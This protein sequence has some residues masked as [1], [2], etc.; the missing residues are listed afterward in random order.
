MSSCSDYTL[1]KAVCLRPPEDVGTSPAP[2]ANHVFYLGVSAQRGCLFLI[3]LGAVWTNA[4]GSYVAFTKKSVLNK[5]VSSSVC[6][7]I[8]LV[9][10]CDLVQLSFSLMKSEYCREQTMTWDLSHLS[11][12]L[13]SL[14]H[15]PDC[16]SHSSAPFPHLQPRR[17]A[18]HFLIDHKDVLCSHLLSGEGKEPQEECVNRTQEMR[19]PVC[20]RRERE[21]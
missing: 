21:K 14:P 3:F 9:F 18:G 12:L 20:E 1:H 6:L 2:L 5:C 10:F 7:M 17:R 19:G 11:N 15:S 4:G 8:F 16:L 13:S